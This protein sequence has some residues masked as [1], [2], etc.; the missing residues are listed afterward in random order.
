MGGQRSWACIYINFISSWRQQTQNTQTYKKNKNERKN[1][2]ATINVKK[3]KE[4][5]HNIQQPAIVTRDSIY[6][7]ARIYAIARAGASN[8]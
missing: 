1:I 4:K 2:H 3:N 6:V 8:N 5:K 7:I